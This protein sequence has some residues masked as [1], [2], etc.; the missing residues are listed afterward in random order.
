[1]RSRTLILIAI[2]AC[3]SQVLAEDF[4][5]P[6]IN[7]STG[8]PDNIVTLLQKRMDAGE[9]ELAFTDEHGYLPAVLKEL[10]VPVSSQMLVFSKTSMQRDRISPRTPRAVYFND[11]V[12]LGFCR[13]GEV[14]EVA[15][16]DAKLGTVFYTLNQEPA[17][18]PRF[19]RQTD[20]C[21][22]CHV[23]R[24]QGI[25]AL[26]VRSV[27][28]DRDGNPILSGGSFR[29]D[30]SSPLK[31]RWGGWY[32]TG[33]HGRQ[34]HLGNL[35]LS[36]RSVP[37]DL[38]NDAGLNVT[39]LKTRTDPGAYLS[40]LSDLVAL[41]VLE[42]QAEM[43]NRITA[44][45]YQTQLAHRD[46]DV[47][48]ELDNALKG[49][50][51]ES[52]ARRVDAAAEQLVKYLLFCDEVR[53]TDPIT[54]TSDFTD[55]FPKA[56]PRDP[57]GRSLRDFDLATRLFKY[58]CS[59]LIYSPVFDGLPASVRGYVYRRLWEVLTGKETGKEYAH[60]STADRQAIREILLDTKSGLPEYWKH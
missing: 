28:P 41:M 31:E 10:K 55:D 1:M 18:R 59:Y 51:T 36:K 33:T 39:D 5:Q 54:G 8:R 4:D 3:G 22:A 50:L 23:S 12:Y 30:H 24:H 29:T 47:I 13:L 19:Q 53:L 25:P 44:A 15:V 56:G 48:N 35:I 14:M 6:P 20:H 38:T 57:K 42:H 32:V 40:P 58:P 60:L 21:L 27:Y 49:R 7:Y 17:A 9:L 45:N 2:L 43:H 34:T 16:P 52:T 11:E 37:D 46:A 26:V